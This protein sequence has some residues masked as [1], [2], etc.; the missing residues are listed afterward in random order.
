VGEYLAD[1]RSRALP[2]ALAPYFVRASSGTDKDLAGVY[3]TVLSGVPAFDGADGLILE[4]AATNPFRQSVDWGHADWSKLNVS[5][6][7]GNIV[8]TVSLAQHQVQLT[9]GVGTAANTDV[10]TWLEVKPLAG[11]ASRRIRMTVYTASH[12]LRANFRIDNM[13]AVDGSYGTGSLAHASIKAIDDGYYLIQMAGKFSASEIFGNFSFQFLDDAGATTYTGDGVSGFHVRHVQ[14]ETG[15][16]ATSRIPTT[17]AAVT[18]AKA[19]L[20]NIPLTTMGLLSQTNEYTTHFAWKAPFSSAVANP[21]TAN[22]AISAGASGTDR[23]AVLIGNSAGQIRLSGQVNGVTVDVY[24]FA[25]TWAVGDVLNVRFSKGATNG[26]ILRVN[27]SVATDTTASAK[28]AFGSAVTIVG[29]NN[30]QDGIYSM[31]VYR[32]LRVYDRALSDAELSALTLESLNQRVG[33]KY[34]MGLGLGLGL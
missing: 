27:N 15:L 13:T 6:T 34:T 17:T 16:V 2:A 12:G 26:W 20:G 31:G 19:Y 8:E 10:I 33:S 23:M 7:G 9:Y 14:Y 29:L 30:R 25:E 11:S 22:I 18:R 28:A 24:I 5:A 4:A 3:S 1:F 32:G 21:A